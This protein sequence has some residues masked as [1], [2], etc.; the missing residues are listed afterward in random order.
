MV[1]FRIFYILKSLETGILLWKAAYITKTTW[2]LILKP[3]RAEISKTVSMQRLFGELKQGKLRE[4]ANN[5]SDMFAW[6]SGSDMGSVHYI[7]F[8]IL[9]YLRFNN[10]DIVH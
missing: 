10:A 3:E 4:R 6:I 5:L 1:F 8:M 2:K 7:R 9:I